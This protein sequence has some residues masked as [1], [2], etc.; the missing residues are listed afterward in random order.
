MDADATQPFSPPAATHD[1][2]PG[3]LFARFASAIPLII[4]GF[5]LIAVPIAFIIGAVLG[6]TQI[7]RNFSERQ[8]SRIEEFL[9][10]PREFA[11]AHDTYHLHVETRE[12]HEQWNRTTT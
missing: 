4:S 3:S 8:Q 7:Y 6:N 12:L 5:A 10:M 1:A 9:H 2:A 11:G